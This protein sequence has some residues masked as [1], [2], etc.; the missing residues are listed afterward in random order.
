MGQHCN[1]SVLP[2][3]S[4]NRSIILSHGRGEQYL[5]EL[6]W[7]VPDDTRLL[8]TGPVADPMIIDETEIKYIEKHY[9]EAPGFISA[10]INLQSGKKF[11]ERYPGK[12]R[13][14]SIFEH[15][16]LEL[17]GN[18]CTMTNACFVAEL[19]PDSW[20]DKVKVLTLSDYLWNSMSTNPDLALLK[21]LISNFGKQTSFDLIRLN[22]A[23]M[24]LYEMY[25]KIKTKETKRKYIRS[26][27]D[28]YRQLEQIMT[29]LRSELHGHPIIPELN[30][31]ADKAEGFYNSIQA[32]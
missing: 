2:H 3:W 8:W 17:P 23:Y 11:L 4:D 27:E 1:L 6:S 24:G 14:G 30:L 28:F 18:F 29:S 13:M 31:L 25:G 20:I 19:Y 22:E 7:Q 26:A 12:A 21:I 9:G 5:E 32:K 10:D 15:F 16:N